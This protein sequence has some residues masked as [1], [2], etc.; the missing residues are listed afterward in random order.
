VDSVSGVLVGPGGKEFRIWNQAFRSL[1][2]GHVLDLDQFHRIPA[3]WKMSTT[4]P[5][6]SFSNGVFENAR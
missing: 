4:A 2:F 1:P 3:P 5:S 6:A